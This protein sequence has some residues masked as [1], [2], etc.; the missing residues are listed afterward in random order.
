MKILTVFGTRPEAVKMAPV[1]R[2][3]AA[4][5]GVEARVCVTAQHRQM[6]D[7]VLRL[8]KIQPDYDL[9][10]MRDGQTLPQ[11]SADIFTHLDPVLED[12]KPDWV[13]AQG[14]TTTVAITS[15]LCYY[16]RIK[17]G[18]VEAGL[19]THDKWAPFPEEVNRRI[20]GVV[21]DLHFAPTDWSKENLLREGVDEKI[22]KVTGNTVIDALQFV[23]KQ[24]EPN[25]VKE[26]LSKLEIEKD[27]RK[28]ILVTAH[29]RENFGK[30]MENICKA[31]FDLSRRGDVEIVYPV[32]LNPNVQEPVNRLLKDVK[33]ITLL[34]PLD[35][36]PLVHLMK[37]AHLILTDSGGIQE[38]APA[39]GIP[40]LVLR[41]VTE[42][43]EGVT[44]GTLKLVGT[45]TSNI[46]NEA[47]LL[48]DNPDNYNAMAGA[49]NPYGDGQAAIKIAHALVE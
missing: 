42:R 9:N 26:L 46:I 20:A 15:L 5:S 45:E 37:H 47:N 39:F 28:L 22:I 2:Q 14:D 7:Q 29:R 10:L 13:L 3:L 12:F 16:R 32:H 33:H 4:T 11:L 40:T 6:L 19:R 23:A 27:K 43:P 36:L 41:D 48:L 44:A 25:D 18:H 34:P 17:F 24:N 1:V 35:Y 49:S 38:E 30:P 8:F 31:L 21:A